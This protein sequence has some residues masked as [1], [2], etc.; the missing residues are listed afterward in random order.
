MGPLTRRLRE[1]G[2]MHS[3]PKFKFRGVKGITKRW[4]RNTMAVICAVLGFL[5][6][7]FAL[8][9]HSYYYSNIGNYMKSTAKLYNVSFVNLLNSSKKDFNTA[10]QSLTDNFIDKDKMEVVIL[11][12]NGSVVNEPSEFAPVQYGVPQDFILA[13]S[14]DSGIGQWS[15]INK[16]TGEKIMAVTIII[17][18]QHGGKLGA[19]RYVTSLA[20][21]D[22]QI[23][24]FVFISGILALIIIAIVI[25]SGLYFINSIVIPVREVGATARRIASGDFYARIAK[26]NDDEIGELCDTINYM[27]NELSATEQMKNDFISSVSH[28]LRTPLTA[29][30][31]WGETILS[32]GPAD[33]DTFEKGMGVI[34]DE[35]GRL[36]TM[37]E[38]LLDFSRMQNGKFKL[39]M[40]KIDV[41]AE[42]GEAVLMFSDRA[43]R[44]GLTFIYNEP[45]SLPPVM[46]DRNRLR[47]VFVNIL[48]NA[49]KYS[50]KGG[51]VAVSTVDNRTHIKIL[52]SDTGCG[53]PKADLKR[54]KV[55][56]YKGNSTRHG[57]GIGLAVADEIICLHGGTLDI[58]SD[59]GKGTTVTITLPTVLK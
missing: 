37:V 35:T 26:K 47:Q 50:D 33:R 18:D 2:K 8:A 36:S 53:I 49:F 13:N 30:R 14:S 27:A 48:D 25:L 58:A 51:I 5:W 40:D 45:E 22:A 4:L 9:M 7:F 42:L 10:A 32:T 28:E 23:A 46:G 43:H 12:S 6:I 38:E 16:A 11:N 56:F 55:K 19:V 59:V 15:G 54:V 17:R 41:L 20:K 34:I 57:S 1:N 29:I 52:I 31:G 24:L 44:E 21:A 3:L 39:V